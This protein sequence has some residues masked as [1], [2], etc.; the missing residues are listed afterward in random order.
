MLNNI[1][2][3]YQDVNIVNNLLSF[4]NVVIH[5]KNILKNENNINKNFLKTNDN[6]YKLKLNLQFFADEGAGGEKTE[7][8]SDYRKEKAREEGQVAKSVEINTA[9]LIVG[10]FFALKMTASFMYKNLIKVINQNFVLIES[11][12]GIF[13]PS[14]ASKW[15]TRSF[16]DILFTALPIFAVAMV[17]GLVA[18]IIQVGWK[19]TSKALMPKFN[20]LNPIEGMKRIFSKKAFLELFKSLGKFALIAFVIY[21]AIADEIIAMVNL[22]N[23]EANEAMIYIGK[24]AISLGIKVGAFFTIIA[25]IDYVFQRRELMKNL[26]MSKQEVKEEYKQL[27]GDPNIKQQRRNKQ[28]QMSMSRMMQDV[29]TAD[30]IITN[31]THFAVAIKYDRDD[32]RPPYVV[33]K[34]QDY[35]AQRIK[36][37]AREEKIEIVENKPL[38]RTLYATVDVGESIPEELYQSVAE[39]LAFVYK[40]QGKI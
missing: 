2:Y 15:I 6:K 26:R 37:I 9:F 4:F 11:P 27:E 40:L 8:P 1:S 18:N 30:V 5:N 28:R 3:E 39:V 10:L 20:R 21:T 31:P 35:M 22:V 17:L 23:V 19:P 13:T 7:A 16:G 34:G 25:V 29:K 32:P 14:A 38:A 33:A 24:V 12:D 36:D